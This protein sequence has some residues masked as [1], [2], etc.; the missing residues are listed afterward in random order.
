MRRAEGS[1]RADFSAAIPSCTPPVRDYG[2]AAR[3]DE[4]LPD[5]RIAIEENV[6]WT[7]SRN[8]SCGLFE[9]QSFARQYS[10]TV[11]DC[12]LKETEG[13]IA[14][15][16]DPNFD[17]LATNT[18]AGLLICGDPALAIAE[19]ELNDQVLALVSR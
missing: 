14:I 19:K 10:K 9:R 15:L 7:R 18:T 8:L 1:G 3:A 4:R 2:R 16:S 5:R 17:C 13:R 12:L 11:K 6:A